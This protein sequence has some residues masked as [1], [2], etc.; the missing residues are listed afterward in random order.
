MRASTDASTLDRRYSSSCMP[1]RLCDRA[2]LRSR[3]LCSACRRTVAPRAAAEPS[4]AEPSR[5]ELSRAEISRGRCVAGARP[6][7]PGSAGT[8]LQHAVPYCLCG[9]GPSASQFRTAVPAGRQTAI[10]ASR[11]RRCRCTPT[12]SRRGATRPS[13]SQAAPASRPASAPSRAARITPAHRRAGWDATHAPALL[14][15]T[16]RMPTHRSAHMTAVR[17]IEGAQKPSMR[18][19][20]VRAHA[21]ACRA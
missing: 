11:C 12:R 3:W 9:T 7:G 6:Q 21:R 17:S 1:L 15:S 4:R 8:T 14:P 20:A 13:A 18:E 16:R 19:R 2:A 5:A 10:G